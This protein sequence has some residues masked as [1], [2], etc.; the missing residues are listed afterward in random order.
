MPKNMNTLTLQK[1]RYLVTVADIGSVTGAAKALFV[2]QP[3]LTKT[4]REVEDEVGFHIYKRTARGIF[5]THKGEEFLA[6]ARQ[7][8]E[9]AE[10]LQGKFLQ[11]ESGKRLFAI[12]SQHYSFAVRAFADLIREHEGDM[13][14]FSFRE[15]ETYA[16]IEDVAEMRS[17]L[18][19]LY[20]NEFNE[21]VLKKLFRE[22]DCVFTE[23]VEARPH[24]FLSR[25]HPLAERS[26]VRLSDLQA[27]PYLFYDQGR[28]NS[29]YFSEEMFSTEEHARKVRVSDRA[30]LF[31][32]LIGINGYTVCSGV[33]DFELTNPKIVA[34]P[35]K[36][37]GSM[38][39]GYICHRNRQLGA[40]SLSFIASLKRYAGCA[41][42][43]G[44][45][46]V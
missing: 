10:L 41:L 40:L 5:T 21:S 37:K 12:S 30:T 16:I 8:L 26:F 1:M 39:I 3:S 2:S 19:I 11:K 32:L 46:I 42:D 34:L 35:L 7:V 25:E 44:S 31:N 14:D 45:E 43:A 33:H 27:Y 17:A 28:H 29:F 9:Q 20:I 4:I 24:V 38:H 22:R 18:G 15:T 6:Y 23:I 13:Y 36:H